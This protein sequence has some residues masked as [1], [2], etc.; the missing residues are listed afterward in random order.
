MMLCFA[1][2]AFLLAAQGWPSAESDRTP[3]DIPEATAPSTP[4]AELPES[5]PVWSHPLQ[6]LRQ[7]F[8]PDPPALTLYQHWASALPATA[9]PLLP[10]YLVVSLSD[11][12]VYLYS[13]DRILASYP[14]AIGKDG[15][16]TPLGDF[17]VTRMQDDLTW[18]HPVT[19]ERIPAGPDSPVGTRWIEFW[20]R[21]RDAFGFH[22]TNEADLIGQAVS[23][24]CLRMTNDDIEALYHNVYPGMPVSVVP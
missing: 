3:T 23:H 19:G 15:W 7:S 6:S 4:A 8:N 18:V 11:R 16:E 13:G 12:Q 5:R 24:G 21:D 2:S 17:Q 22:G 1:G 20:R 9:A 10:K 14:V